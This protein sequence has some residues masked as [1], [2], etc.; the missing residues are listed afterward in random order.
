MAVSGI[1]KKEQEVDKVRQKI[2]ALQQ[3]IGLVIKGK[4]NC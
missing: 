2:A 1:K 4:K 3:N